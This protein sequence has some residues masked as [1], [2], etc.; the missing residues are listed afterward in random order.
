MIGRPRSAF[1]LLAALL[2]LGGGIVVGAFPIGRATPSPEPVLATDSAP[3]ADS[4]TV[5][6]VAFDPDSAAP[7]A[8]SAGGSPDSAGATQ[9]A[10]VDTAREAGRRILV[11]IAE[12]RLWLVDGDD[13]LLAAP[14]AIGMGKDFTYRGRTYHF[15][16]PR[17]ERRVIAK[18]ANP[19]WIVP[20]W[21][22]YERAAAMS[23]SEVI[24]LE[25]DSRIQLAD[26]SWLV[27]Q[28][29]QVG[30][31][32]HFG[33]FAP[34][35]AGTEIIYDGRI[36]VPPLNSAQRRVPEALGPYKLDMGDGYLIHG[37]HPYNEESIGEAVSHGC[38]RMRN[39]DLVRLYPLVPRGTAVIIS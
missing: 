4:I 34:F 16:T 22:Y 26:S 31:I 19:V 3:A 36:Y 12:R 11:S 9:A 13:T 24:R 17:G 38:V 14:V 5:E 37:T 18:G 23:L 8:D 6:I 27:V 35:T 2:A 10:T 21:H 32:N 25:A 1:L 20:E 33:H 30:R 29:E 39:E 28:G 15:A 7:R